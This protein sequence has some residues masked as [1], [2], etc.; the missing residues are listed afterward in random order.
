MKLYYSAGACSLA[1]HILLRD[2]G[3]PF[4]LARVDLQAH[5]TSE[6]ADYYAINPS[7]FVPVLEFDDGERLTEG[8]IIAQWICDRA[9][10]TDLM[11]AAG[12]MARYRVMEWQN[13]VTAELHK[14]FSPLFS[15]DVNDEAKQWFRAALRKKYELVASRLAKQP[16]LTGA[17]F[18][19][20]DAYLFVVT[21]WARN[22]GLDLADLAPVQEFLNRV[23]ERDAVQAALKAETVSVK[24][25]TA[26]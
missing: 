25:S 3:L 21:R 13:Y 11:P 22:T 16:F 15:R 14:F 1:P 10:R 24:K 18:T 26:A 5:K 8:P 4:E 23:A 7:G 17:T 12:T 20:A 19:A 6:G 9:G 2:T